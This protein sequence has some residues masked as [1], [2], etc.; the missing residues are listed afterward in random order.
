[1]ANKNKTMEINRL[2][3]EYKRE[4][5]KIMN[6]DIERIKKHIHAKFKRENTIMSDFISNPTQHNKYEIANSI[7]G[8]NEGNRYPETKKSLLKGRDIIDE[9]LYEN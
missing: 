3:Q 7:F 5:K 9:M 8:P 4:Y 1:M 6:E 2:Y